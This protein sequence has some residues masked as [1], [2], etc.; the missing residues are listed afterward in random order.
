MAGSDQDD[1]TEEPTPKRLEDA[2]KRGE[3]VYSA[4]AAAFLALLGGYALMTM[5]A[6]HFA[7]MAHWLS[8]FLA[9]GHQFPADDRSLQRLGV[10]LT[11]RFCLVL[12][13]IGGVMGAAGVVARYLQDQA[14]FSAKKLQPKLEN[15]NPLSGFKRVLG[16]QAVANLLKGLAKLAVVGGAIAWGAWPKDAA[17]ETL[18]MLDVRSFWPVAQ[19][20][21]ARLVTAC[22]IAFAVVAGA[23]YLWTRHSYRRRL[24]MSKQEIKEELKQ[25]EGDPHIRARQRAIRQE[26]ARRRMMQQVPKATVVITNPTHYAVALR[27]VAGE[28][29]APMCVAKGV[30]DVALRI[31]DV[32]K[33]AEVPLVEDPPLARALYATAEI[34]AQIPREH[35][36]AVAKVIGFVMRL[37]ERRR[38]ARPP[39]RP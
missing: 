11:L 38:S 20:R 23:D 3:I 16:P 35:F 25:T 12:A 26:R 39:N 1:K 34:D 13:L 33:G 17:L 4:E 21:S 15:L 14:T 29:A 9:N 28:T 24:R 5:G 31:R 8:A 10:N 7:K 22:L 30:D 32:A 2:R 19:E 37:N 18:P 6:D 27:Y 36:E